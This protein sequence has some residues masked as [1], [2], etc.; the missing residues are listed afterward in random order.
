MAQDI[1][2]PP[3]G[4]VYATVAEATAFAVRLLM[5]HR[6]PEADARTVAHCLV[7]ADL[8]GVKAVGAR[9][10]K[11]SSRRCV[12]RACGDAPAATVRVR[13]EVR[14]RASVAPPPRRRTP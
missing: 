5:A 3:A 6:L 4:T 2:A 12:A 8:R 11:A 13:C 7:R 1:D 9:I 14:E 10:K